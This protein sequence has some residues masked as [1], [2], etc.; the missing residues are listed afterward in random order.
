V[1]KRV[2]W[3]DN[4]IPYIR[5]YVNALKAKN[6]EVDYVAS[7]SRA[8]G[9]LL[10]KSFDLIIIDV[11]VPTQ[12][13]SELRD[14]PDAETDYG[15]KTGLVFFNR[16]KRKLGKG[17]PPVLIMTVRL[18]QEIRDEFVNSGLKAESFLTK[19]DV[20]DVGDFMKKV[21]RILELQ[22]SE[23]ADPAVFGKG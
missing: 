21:N 5:P 20:R 12:N 14:Y 6:Y 23:C 3:L 2:L 13:D 15:H 8:E 10:D 11:M 22:S 18:D 19:Y 9:L 16:I 1:S 7:L 4:D 17:L